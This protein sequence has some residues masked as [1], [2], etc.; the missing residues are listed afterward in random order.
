LI[1]RPLVFRIPKHGSTR[2]EY[3]DAVAWSTRRRRFAVADG[4][5]ASAFARAWAELLARA[6]T[7]G[8]LRADH[9]TEDLEPIQA[10]WSRDVEQR[11]LPWYAHEQVRRGAFAA[12]VGL[13]IDENHVWHA[14]AVGDSCLFQLRGGELINAFP[15][16]HSEEFNNRPMLIGSR[17]AANAHVEVNTAHGEWQ[18]GD[19]FMLMSDAIAATFLQERHVNVR[20][21]RQWVHQMRAERLMRN[22]DVSLL[23]LALP[24]HAA[25]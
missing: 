20:G 5:S 25:A 14:L 9:L 23:H 11:D 2:A 13:T 7:R 8:A 18:S 1:P 21:F 4:A 10:L 16:T 3:E 6:F 15:L 19:V 12:L 22:D 24:A 17:A